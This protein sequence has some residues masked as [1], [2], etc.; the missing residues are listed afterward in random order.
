MLPLST[1]FISIDCH[2]CG[3]HIGL[4]TPIFVS[5]TQS[6]SS[7]RA[8]QKVPTTKRS[9]PSRLSQ[10]WPHREKRKRQMTKN[11][12]LTS[13]SSPHLSL[14]RQYADRGCAVGFK[15]SFLYFNQYH[16]NTLRSYYW[17]LFPALK[18]KLYCRY[19]D[20]ACTKNVF[21]YVKTLNWNF[22]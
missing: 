12:S 17:F 11:Q 7:H 16:R 13:T 3:G 5:P 21:I 18:Q 2:R 8:V 22:F 6:L 20:L 1:V 9:P 14:R 19:K 10:M 15:N 4:S